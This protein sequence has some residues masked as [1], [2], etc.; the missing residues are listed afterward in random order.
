MAHLKLRFGQDSFIKFL[1][2]VASRCWRISLGRRIQWP[3][4][5]ITTVNHC[6]G[7][8][9][10]QVAILL[11]LPVGVDGRTIDPS[12]LGRPEGL[13]SSW[14]CVPRPTQVCGN[15]HAYI[16]HTGHGVI[17]SHPTLVDYMQDAFQLIPCK[18]IE[19]RYIA[20]FHFV[21]VSWQLKVLAH[22]RINQEC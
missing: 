4:T 16:R 3:A 12:D 14:V 18:N 22:E 6:H 17:S 20:N 15:V 5:A 8:G 2:Q 7:P 19:C 9:I 21:Y 11:F 1:V 10:M 13:C